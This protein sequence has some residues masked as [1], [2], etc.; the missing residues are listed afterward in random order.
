MSS[1]VRKT[2]F[3]CNQQNYFSIFK[4]GL[5]YIGEQNPFLQSPNSWIQAGQHDH[6]F[7]S[8]WM[9]VIIRN[10]FPTKPPWIW[11]NRTYT[12]VFVKLQFVGKVWVVETFKSATLHPHVIYQKRWQPRGQR[13]RQQRGHV[14]HVP[15]AFCT[16]ASLWVSNALVAWKFSSHGNQPRVGWATV[17]HGRKRGGCSQN[18]DGNLESS[19]VCEL[20]V[21]YIDDNYM[22]IWLWIMIIFC[23]FKDSKQF[24]FQLVMSSLLKSM[25]FVNRVIWDS[26]P[27]WCN[28]LKKRV[29]REAFQHCL[30]WKIE[31]F[32]QSGVNIYQPTWST[33]EGKSLKSSIYACIVWSPQKVNDPWQFYT[34]MWKFEN[35]SNSE[36]GVADPDFTPLWVHRTP[37][38]SS[39]KLASCS[40]RFR[41][42]MRMNKN[43]P[44]WKVPM[45]P[46]L[47]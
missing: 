6:N 26:L 32:G 1:E 15:P 9:N 30:W 10:D 3:F 13:G 37:C 23:R 40:F 2:R 43:Q 11:V 25:K 47:I 35:C 31:A 21:S 39:Q 14:G 4:F 38:V 27:M 29:G 28:Q 41:S 12:T 45:N 46:L 17:G 5:F 24:P 34:R 19:G 42:C 33:I 7:Y 8:A 16:M 20:V 18:L 36:N 22:I 44:K